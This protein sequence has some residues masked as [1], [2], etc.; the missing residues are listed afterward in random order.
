MTTDSTPSSSSQTSTLPNSSEPSEVRLLLICQA[1]GLRNRYQ[2]L[3]GY[4]PLDDNSG[5]TALGW[6]QANLLATWLKTHEKIDVLISAPQLR[7]R[8]TA[9][10]INQVMGLTLQVRPDLPNHARA[11]LRT[12]G[13]GEEMPRNPLDLH[14]IQPEPDEEYQRFTS[15]VVQA[16]DTIVRENW[17]KSVAI[18]MNGVAVATILR[19]FLGVQLLPI[20]IV[21]TGIAEVARRGSSWSLNY[22]NRRE[23]M[24]VQA[25][26]T[27]GNPTVAPSSEEKSVELEDL[28]LVSQT[29]NRLAPAFPSLS[30]HEKIQ[31]EK[32]QGE[33]LQRLR[34]LFKFASL[35]PDLS[36]IDIGTGV[37]L[38]ALELAQDGA[39]EV[40]GVDISTSML[41]SAEYL[42]LTKGTPPAQRVSYRLAPANLLPF[43]DARFDAAVYHTLLHHSQKPA[44]ILQETLRVLKPGGVLIMAELVGSEDPVKRATYDAIEERRNPAHVQ[45][46]SV[47]QLRKLITVA[48]FTIEAE[49][50]ITFERN[51]EEW[52]AEYQVDETRR[53]VVRKMIEAGLEADAAGLNARRQGERLLIEQRVLYVKA[54]K[55]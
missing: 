10:R 25:L 43:V 41:E 18:V 14:L 23:H 49:K 47:E 5:L 3:A 52:V 29:F 40:I 34:Q 35:P 1:E 7:S 32:Q 6:E 50:G 55:K 2:D 15:S 45:M 33:Q 4:E 17:G 36:I 16:I 38:L 22:V 37:G 48:G 24:P 31:I 26:R 20:A 42:R 11:Q 46:R 44:A 39:S 9:Q 8:L 19:H 54:R 13:S 21:H 51:L 28:S 53:E 27:N 12:P 30:V